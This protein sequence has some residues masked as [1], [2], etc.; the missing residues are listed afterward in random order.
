MFEHSESER[1]SLFI[2]REAQKIIA[3]YFLCKVYEWLKF[4]FVFIF[5][6]KFHVSNWMQK[7]KYLFYIWQQCLVFSYQWSMLFLLSKS[8]CIVGMLV[9]QF[10]FYSILWE[11][12]WKSYNKKISNNIDNDVDSKYFQ[13]YKNTSVSCILIF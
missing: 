11:H 9:I 6:V 8:Y 5:I 4:P 2:K 3:I 10:L 1:Y 7:I 12:E 13:D